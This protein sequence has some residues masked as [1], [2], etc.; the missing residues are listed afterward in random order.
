MRKRE[1][2]RRRVNNGVKVIK[3]IEMTN[4]SILSISGIRSC[5]IFIT[6]SSKIV[7]TEHSYLLRFLRF[8]NI[9]FTSFAF[10][11]PFSSNL[12]ILP[13]L[14]LSLFYIL[15]FYSPRYLFFLRPRS[16]FSCFSTSSSVITST[17][18][19]ENVTARFARFREKF[20]SDKEGQGETEKERKR[21]WK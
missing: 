4:F 19:L 9:A 13:S 14:P 15:V 1:R 21:E 20:F 16:S 17:F 12:L 5:V 11:P 10:S 6:A 7:R 18:L 3:K 8:I 2:V